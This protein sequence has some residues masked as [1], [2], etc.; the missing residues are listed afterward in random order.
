MPPQIS[1]S[2][3]THKVLST[4]M[5]EVSAIINESPLTHLDGCRLTLTSDSNDDHGTESLHPSSSSRILRKCRFL[6][7]T[8]QM[9]SALGKCSL[10][11]MEA[12]ISLRSSRPE[13]LAGCAF[14][15]QKDPVLLRDIW[16]KKNLWPMTLV[17]Q[18]APWQ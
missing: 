2:H 15:C 12:R 17:N 11:K 3:L 13:Q 4:F 6:S 7:S 14:Q 16:V 18:N 5:A 8:V 1:P 9:C 10:G